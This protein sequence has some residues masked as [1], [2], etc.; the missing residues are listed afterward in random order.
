MNQRS[1][2]PTNLI[3]VGVGLLSLTP[4]LYFVGGSILKYELHLLPNVT[5]HPI[6]P[7][8]LLGGLILAIAL[9]LYPALQLSVRL[10][11]GTLTFSMSLNT[12]SWSLPILLVSSVLL[13][14]LVGYVVTENFLEFIEESRAH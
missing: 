5:I 13:I 10:T 4:A 3:L 8:I 2:S 7:I 11:D 6:H 1:S 9:N 14:V 12:R